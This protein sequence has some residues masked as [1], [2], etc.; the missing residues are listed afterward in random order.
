MDG[1]DL[2]G[3]TEEQFQGLSKHEAQG[4]ALYNAVRGFPVLE[5]QQ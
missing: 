1:K 4:I 3:L 2:A 5:I